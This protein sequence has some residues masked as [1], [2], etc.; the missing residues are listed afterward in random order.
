MEHL[1][2]IDVEEHFQMVSGGRSVP[3]RH[4]DRFEPRLGRT[5]EAALDLLGETGTKAT[6]FVG[7]WV[8]T[9]HADVVAG[10][11][12][13]GHEVACHLDRRFASPASEARR[14][15]EA[16]SGCVVG[17]CRI[18]H[19][20]ALGEQARR[21]VAE[22]FRYESSFAPLLG[23]PRAVGPVSLPVPSVRI[24]GQVWPLDALLLRQ[25]SDAQAARSV[26]SWTR[27]PRRRVLSFRLWEL[28][29]ELPRLAVLS[30]AQR[31]LRHRNLA[32][33]APRLRTLLRE[34]RFVPVRA[35][36]GLA[37]ERAARP[38]ACAAAAD[39][40]LVQTPAPAEARPLTVVVPCFNEEESLAYLGNALGALSSG[41][42]RRRSLSFVLVDDGSTDGTWREMERLFGT[43]T[44]FRLVRHDRNRGVGAA[45]LTGMAEAETEAV[46]VIDSDCSYDPAHIEEMLPLLGPD[47]ALV[48]ASPYHALGGV[49][50]V[51]RWRLVLSRGASRLYRLVLNNK[52][53]TY[54]SCFRV[55]RRSAL[56]GLRLRHEG[57]IGVAETLARLDLEGWRIAEHPV[58]LETRLL[59]Q[60]KLK[61][62]AATMGHLRL[63]CE[64]AAARLRTASRGVAVT[65]HE[66]PSSR[67]N[68]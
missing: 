38:A 44:K 7:D 54:T 23:G 61:V 10:I 51:P 49:E 40:A 29:E 46:A 56:D 8:A 53:A 24:A 17:G 35:G 28:D 58:V 62:L 11:A 50:G 16:V 6:F 63:L 31:R 36:L 15:L 12:R 3:P 55:Y 60:S 68:S 66:V 13:A 57:F 20:L 22:A 21:G 2:T 27:S 19:D 5:A 64:I 34:A 39:P 45:I 32:L 33:F 4:W 1:L 65:A 59:G 30:P 26:A 9:R 52:L 43:D 18:A 41:L 47:V 67:G 25:G 37:E 42:G 14:R 48:T